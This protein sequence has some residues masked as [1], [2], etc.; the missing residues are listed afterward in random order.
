MA[1]PVLRHGDGAIINSSFPFTGT[2]DVKFK[3]PLG[4]VME[5]NEF[6]VDTSSWFE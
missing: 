6:N 2:L 3:A 4:S 1:V 5:V